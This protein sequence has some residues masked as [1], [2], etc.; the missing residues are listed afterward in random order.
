VALRSASRRTLWP[1]AAAAALALILSLVDYFTP[2]GAIAGTLGALVVAASTA[3]MLIAA[4][5]LALGWVRGWIGSTFNALILL[6]ILGTGFAAYMLEED[7]LL[8][9]MALALIAWLFETFA[10]RRS[11]APVSAE[12]AS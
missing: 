3:L 6:D 1:L 11:P 10:G 8:G 4:V 12:A 9:L 7:A 5:L 2:H